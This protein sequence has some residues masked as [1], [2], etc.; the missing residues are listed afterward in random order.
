MLAQ[1]K[2]ATLLGLSV[3][4]V[5]IEVDAAAGL[6]AWDIVGLPDTAVKESKER[7][8]TAVRNAGYEFPPRRIVVNLAPAYLRKEGPSF[9]LAM[10]IA[11]LVVTGQLTCDHLDDF[12]LLGELG[13]DG[14]L[15]PVK[16]V[17]PI[18]L[19]YAKSGYRL[20]VPVANQEESAIGGSVSYGFGHLREVAYFLEHPD[21]ARPAEARLPDFGTL[22]ARPGLHDFARIR[23]QAEARRALEI[24]AA[25]NHNILMVGSPGSGKTMLSQA[26]PGIL[27]PFTFAE[28]LSLSKIYSIAGLLPPNQPLVLERPF[29]SPHHSASAASIIGGGRI[30][31]PGEVSLSHHGVLFLD[32][33]P[34]YRREVL[35]AL[36]QPLEDGE[37]TVSRVQAQVTFPCRFLLVA[38]MNPCPCGYLNDPTRQCTCTPGQL[39]RYRS[40]IS[41]PLLD[42]FDLQ[43]EV[44]PVSFQELH[45]ESPEEDS[46]TIR[47]RVVAARRVQAERFAGS[48][49]I[50]NGA[51]TPAQIQQF[52]QLDAAG[53]AF[54]EQAF[55]RLGLSARAHSRILKVAR[56]IADLAGSAEIQLNHLAEAIQY[57]TLDKKM[58]LEP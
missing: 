26:L 58:W 57:R 30:P 28:S 24:A 52:C 7:V 21:S 35:E 18:S 39:Q 48:D 12:L 50:H 32:E 14:S 11:I 10:A 15:R 55:H 54:L 41:G 27:P 40:K 33:F 23:G 49:T 8:R 4:L 42:R 34:E 3:S 22:A 43:L 56:T 16:G 47:K 19:E 5:E 2:S 53:S 31:H 36:R 6:P 46:A 45:R 37:V 20:I 44:V 1:L 29:R 38:S 9:D 51:M 17:L 13:L 25:G